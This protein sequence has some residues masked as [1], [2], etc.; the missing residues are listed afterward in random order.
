MGL[1]G[2]RSRLHLTPGRAS[3][4]LPA[5][6]PAL[7]GLDCGTAASPGPSCDKRARGHRRH[8]HQLTGTEDILSPGERDS[9]GVFSPCF[10]LFS[11]FLQEAANATAKMGEREIFLNLVASSNKPNRK[12]RSGQLESLLQ[13]HGFPKQS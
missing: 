9:W 3:H 5:Q 8:L 13:T 1:M 11:F 7:P 4:L 10:P 12:S 2:G 6:E